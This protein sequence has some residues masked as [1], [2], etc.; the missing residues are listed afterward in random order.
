MYIALCGKYSTVD[1]TIVQNTR[2]NGFKGSD[3][4]PKNEQR[5]SPSPLV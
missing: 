1:F 5:A 3:K 4:Q 2:L